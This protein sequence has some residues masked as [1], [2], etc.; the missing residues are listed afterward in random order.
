M[1]Y[2]TGYGF[3]AY[4]GGPMWYADAVGLDNVYQRICR[5]EARHG[6]LWAPAPLLKNLAEAGKKFSDVVGGAAQAKGSRA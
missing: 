4:R 3:P 1:I 5:F 2:V 6:K